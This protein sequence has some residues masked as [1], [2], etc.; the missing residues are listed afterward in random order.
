M[1]VERPETRYARSGE[2]NI[3]YQVVGDG[4]YD[5]VLVPGFISNVEYGWEEPGLASFY[6]RLA[7]FSR[8][9]LF[10]KRGTGLSDRVTG[11]PT[12]ETR[13]D[14]VRAILDAIG[15]RRAA[16]IGYSEG[17]SMS[18]LFAATYPER[19]AALIMYGSFLAWDW[20]AE[21]RFP[22]RHESAKRA[23]A[24]IE[25]RWGSPDFCDELLENDAPSMLGDGAFRN[26]YATRLRLSASPSAAADLQRMNVEIDTRALLPSIHVPTLIVHREGDLNV[27][28]Q[29]ARYAAEHIAG[30]R[31]VELPGDDHLPWVGDSEAIVGEIEGFLTEIWTSGWEAPA[32]DRVLATVLF[33]DIVESTA[34]AVELGDSRW[35]ELIGAHHDRVRSQI[36]RFRGTEMDTAGDG[37]FARFD[38]PA[39]AIECARAIRDSVQEL[40][41]DIR[42]GLHTGECEQMDSKVGG[43]AVITGARIAAQAASNEILVSATV[44]DLV[45]GS[46]L[47]FEDR[48]VHALSGLPEEKHLYAVA[49]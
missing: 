12:L 35:R 3:A 5:L 48:G 31:Y 41:I 15:S 24:E 1:A 28:V 43:I 44:R 37:F 21:G 47:E 49:G 18:A 4:P 32:P 2:V 20:M 39:R 38:G 36:A 46:G 33:T 8:L 17:A 42:A 30:A 27:D 23:I 22:T 25:Q 13:M 34:K 26:W 14:D 10:D 45:A 11:V 6:R 19:T 29:N 9:I 40:G 16:V 7:S